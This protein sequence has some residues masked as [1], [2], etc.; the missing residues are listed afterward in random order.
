M[1]IKSIKKV[2]NSITDDIV[3]H[4][5]IKQIYDK[6]EVLI[7]DKLYKRS[8]TLHIREEQYFLTNREID[9]ICD[10][11]LNMFE[12]LLRA[13]FNNTLHMV[14]DRGIILFQTYIHKKNDNDYHLR[15]YDHIFSGIPVHLDCTKTSGNFLFSFYVAFETP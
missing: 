11:D 14:Q 13:L 5:I 10:G 7:I 9:E 4:D 15:I 12:Y 2:L 8:S 3:P 6:H 1:K